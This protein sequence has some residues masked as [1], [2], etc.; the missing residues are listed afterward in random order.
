MMQLMMIAAGLIQKFTKAFGLPT[1]GEM[2]LNKLRG[3]SS[4]SKTMTQNTLSIQQRT[5]FGRKSGRFL[6][7]P[8]QSA[9]LKPIEHAFHLLKRR[10][11]GKTPETNN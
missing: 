2:S 1:Y 9:D 6:D 7:W 8:I 11:K 4:C 3:T 10:L 5:S